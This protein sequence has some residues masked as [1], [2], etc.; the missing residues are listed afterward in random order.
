MFPKL[1]LKDIE[2]KDLEKRIFFCELQYS[3]LGEQHVALIKKDNDLA[4]H[5]LLKG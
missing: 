5:L 1:D 4:F 2:L 3:S